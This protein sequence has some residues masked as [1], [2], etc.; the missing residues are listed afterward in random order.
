MLIEYFYSAEVIKTLDTINLYLLIAASFFI[1]IIVSIAVHRVLLLKDEETST[2]GIYRFG[3][4]ELNFTL[5]AIGL[6][7]LIGLLFMLLFTIST[8]LGKVFENL[9]GSTFAI[10]YNV[11]SIVL[12]S[13]F[14]GL[15][16]FLDFL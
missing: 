13:I 9:L 8:F 12:I 3:R 1:N 7:L 4:R 14:C 5:K 6:G 10:Y 11:I 2:L 15:I 16:F